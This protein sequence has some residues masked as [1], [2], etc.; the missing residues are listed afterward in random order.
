MEFDAECCL[1]G[2]KGGLEMELHKCLTFDL[3]VLQ[4]HQVGMRQVAHLVMVLHR[5]KHT[6]QK[7]DPT[8]TP[9]GMEC[10]DDQLSSI[11]MDNLLE[12]CVMERVQEPEGAV[13]KQAEGTFKRLDSPQQ[14][15]LCDSYQKSLVHNPETMVLRAVTLRGGIDHQRVRFNL[16]MYNINMKNSH[17]I[18]AQPVALRIAS[19]DFN[20]S[21][22]KQTDSTAPILQLERSSDDQLRTISAQGDTARFLFYMTTKGISLT[23]FESA[24]YPGWFISTSLE[25]R[26]PVAMCQKED[27]RKLTNF[28]VNN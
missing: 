10:T 19:S 5:M 12:E 18:Q 20:L 1:P 25:Q 27:L 21:C 28:Y 9:L 14:C 13:D 2:A 15:T 6:F 11:I 4:Q 8:H 17:T 26:Q 7:S 3:E 23:T 22:S 16:S 24:K